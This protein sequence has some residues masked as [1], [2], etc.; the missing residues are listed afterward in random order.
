MNVWTGDSEEIP[1]PERFKKQRTFCFK[2][3]KIVLNPEVPNTFLLVDPCPD[4]K[5]RETSV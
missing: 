3:F 5:S 1:H 2:D 4:D